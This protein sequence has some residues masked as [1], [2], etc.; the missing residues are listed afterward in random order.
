MLVFVLILPF[1]WGEF[2]MAFRQDEITANTNL[3]NADGMYVI[4]AKAR[5]AGEN[6]LQIAKDLLRKSRCAV[7]PL[8]APR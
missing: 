6:R 4:F 1:L 3:A 8:L 2:L 5:G 7:W